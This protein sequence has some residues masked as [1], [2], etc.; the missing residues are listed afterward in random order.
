[1]SDGGR[2]VPDGGVARRRGRPTE[3]SPDGECGRAR[4]R[5]RGCPTEGAREPDGDRS[6][7]GRRSR[8]CRTEGAG[9]GG[10][11]DGES[12]GVP[13]GVARRGQK[14]IR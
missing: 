6:G 12:R 5:P 10:W 7:A 13:D 14:Y 3:G 8:G 2:S 9:L 11:P 1:V 4:R